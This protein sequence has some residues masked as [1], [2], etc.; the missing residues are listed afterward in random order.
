MNKTKRIFQLLILL[1]IF[2]S[3]AAQTYKTADDAQ[4]LLPGTKA[5]VF[6]AMDS[7][8]N[9]YSLKKALESG[10]VVMIFYRGFWCPHCNRH[11]SS[12]QDSLELIYETGATVIAVSPEKPEYLNETKEITGSEFTLLYDESY[13]ISDAYDVAFL[14]SKKNLMKYHSDD[15]QRLPIPATY[16]INEDGLITWRHF[17]PNYKKRSTVKDIIQ[18]LTKI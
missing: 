10:P 8:G 11:L 1:I 6:T 13:R 4:G 12:I 16:I 9:N 15:S 2:Q 7:D 14:S 3:T 18:A 17:D 5:P